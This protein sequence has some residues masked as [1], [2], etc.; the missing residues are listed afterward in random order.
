MD[1]QTY[2]FSKKELAGNLAMFLLLDGVIS[3]LFYRSIWAFLLGLPEVIWFLKYRREFYKKK[4]QQ[5]LA[6]QFLSGMQAVSASLVAGYSIETA[7]EEALHEL[8]NMYSPDAMIMKEFRYIITQLH[9]NRSLEELLSGLAERSGVEDIQNFADIFGAA[10]R[11]GGN[12]IAIIRNTIQCISQK[13]ETRMEIQTCLAAKKLEQNIMSL[14]PVLILAYIQLVSP[15]F[16][17]GM[18]HN[19]AGVV[20]MS[21]CLGIYALAW[22]WGRKIVT[23]EV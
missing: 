12:L 5:A 10:K 7:F 23:I 1:Y 13:E 11:T 22:Y 8:R 9:M 15:G 4:R 3:F 18:Y 19:A 20:I 2:H 14:V 6:G 17:D 16:L 21:L